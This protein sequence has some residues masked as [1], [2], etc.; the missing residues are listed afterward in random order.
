MS[1]ET[2]RVTKIFKSDKD[3]AGNPFKT[4]TNKPFW[5]VAIKTEKY[6]DDWFSCLCFRED[7]PEMKLEE[8]VE[9]TLNI[10]ESNG[11]KNFNL[12]LKADLLEGR[13]TKLEDTVR[14]I[15]SHI[16]PKDNGLTSAGTKVPDFSEIDKPADDINPEDI[17]F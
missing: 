13:V 14:K 1:L 8:G 9:Y 5:K 4:K 6:G 12:P 15:I 7:A 2:I 3:K 10:T 17:P 16:K 11:Y